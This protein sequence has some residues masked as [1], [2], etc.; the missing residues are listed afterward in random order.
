MTDRDLTKVDSCNT[1]PLRDSDGTVFSTT[2]LDLGK[3]LFPARNQ[4]AKEKYHGKPTII[5]KG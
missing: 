3:G 2:D 4:E 5:L 1:A